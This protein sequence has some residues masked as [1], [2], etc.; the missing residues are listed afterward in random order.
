MATQYVPLRSCL[1]CGRRAYKMD[2]IRVVKTPEGV[3]EVDSTGIKDGRG[4]YFCPHLK[5]AMDGI[6]K[7]R[8]ERAMRCVISEE[9]RR[10]LLLDYRE[11]V[12][13]SLSRKRL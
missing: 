5:C 13:P 3:V 6:G 8:F 1:A 11:L 9:T 12:S 4:A 10:Q 2:L 7:A